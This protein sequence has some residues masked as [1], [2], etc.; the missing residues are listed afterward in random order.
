MRDLEKKIQVMLKSPK[1]NKALSILN[2]RD[3]DER[4]KLMQNKHEN[5]ILQEEFNE[6][7]QSLLAMFLLESKLRYLKNPTLKN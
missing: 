4:I 6:Y 3:G 1:V 5:K 7:R 2:G